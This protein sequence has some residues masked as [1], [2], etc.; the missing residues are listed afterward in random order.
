[1]R[2]PAANIRGAA[3]Q[4]LITFPCSS[5]FYLFGFDQGVFSGMIMTPYFLDTVHQSDANLLRTINAIYDI[6]GAIGALFCL[7]L[8]IDSTRP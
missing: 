1:M 8:A 4:S 3:L 6:G 5:G 2:K 7:F